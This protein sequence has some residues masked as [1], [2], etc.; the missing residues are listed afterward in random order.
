MNCARC[1][2]NGATVHYT[3]MVNAQVRMKLDLC[4]ACAKLHPELGKGDFA[5]VRRSWESS[6]EPTPAY[7]A[8]LPLIGELQISDPMNVRQLAA[9]LGVEPVR[10]VSDLMIGGIFAHVNQELDFAAIVLVG[11]LHGY[12]VRPASVTE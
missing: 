9:L 11:R 7:P 10:V 5:E 1:G 8:P 12:K 6:Q 2:N 3:V 4:E